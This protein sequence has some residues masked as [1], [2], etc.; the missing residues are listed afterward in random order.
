MRRGGW[1]AAVILLVLLAACGSGDAEPTA[2]IALDG[3][4]RDPDVEGLVGRVSIEEI[5]IDGKRYELS[6]NLQAFN[7]YTLVALPVLRTEGSYVHAGLKSG[8]VVWLAEVAKVLGPGTG[9]TAFYRGTLT[10]VDDGELV[11]QDGTV[12]RPD[13]ELELPEPPV[14]VLASIDPSTDAV[15]SLGSP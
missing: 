11:F 15:V 6:R 7:T 3:S 10:A 14:A 8:K 13:D 2:D 12:L 5:T 9:R 4:R 1:P